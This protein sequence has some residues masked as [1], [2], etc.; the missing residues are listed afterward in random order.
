[1]LYGR[2]RKGKKGKLQDNRLRRKQREEG[3]WRGPR[4]CDIGHCARDVQGLQSVDSRVHTG[5]SSRSS[6]LHAGCPSRSRRRRGEKAGVVSAQGCR[7]GRAV[8][9]LFLSSSAGWR[10]CQIEQGDGRKERAT[11]TL[12]TSSPPLAPIPDRGSILCKLH[13]PHS[14]DTAF[15][16]PQR[17][18]SRPSSSSSLSGCIGAGSIYKALRTAPETPVHRT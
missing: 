5:E 16:C 10:V 17:S 15:A 7:C 6:V 13:L 12:P 4:R 11:S 14:C 1:M 8:R 9:S 2:T 18:H 3:G